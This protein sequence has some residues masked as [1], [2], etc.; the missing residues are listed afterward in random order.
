M[1]RID[2][3]TMA[4]PLLRSKL[5]FYSG[6]VPESLHQ[7][8]DDIQWADHVLLIYPLWLG[9]LPALT[10]GFLEQVLR[11]GFAFQS[12]DGGTSWRRQLGGRSIR[13]VVTMG[14]PALIYRW[15]YGAHSVRSLRRNILSFCGF[16][17]IRTTL[18]GQVES[19]DDMRRIR[20]IMR[21]S[22]W[23]RAGR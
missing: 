6:K 10:K 12:N 23:G 16:G 15:F 5:D 22:E 21:L 18:V 4:F 20:W 1:R 2:V 8:Q 14:L 11:P 9:D 7:A 13:V 17:P 19:L 3:A